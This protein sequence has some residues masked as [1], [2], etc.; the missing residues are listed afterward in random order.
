MI[1][2]GKQEIMSRWLIEIV[3]DRIYQ[4]MPFSKQDVSSSC[5]QEWALHHVRL[6]L[7]AFNSRFY[8]LLLL[9]A[10]LSQLLVADLA[11]TVVSRFL[12][13][14]HLPRVLG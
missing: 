6:A 10:Q 14:S 12:L 8:C 11:N 5:F 3:A 2:I 1:E 4:S 9:N 7:I 13:L